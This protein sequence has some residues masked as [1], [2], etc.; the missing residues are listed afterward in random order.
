VK[1]VKIT[2]AQNALT[3]TPVITAKNALMDFSEILLRSAQ[4]VNRVHAM[5]I[6]VT[7]LQESVSSAR[8]TR[9]V[10]DVKSA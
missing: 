10:G 9:K 3:D 1:K 7:Q 4:N 2:F 8:A 6:L 5:A